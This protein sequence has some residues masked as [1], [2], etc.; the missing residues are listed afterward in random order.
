MV[1]K[2]KKY[3]II[4]INIIFKILKEVCFWVVPPWLAMIL[5]KISSKFIVTVIRV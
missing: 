5:I 3:N 4:N 2:F 1:E